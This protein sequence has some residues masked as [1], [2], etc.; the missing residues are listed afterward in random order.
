MLFRA[1]FGVAH[2]FLRIALG[3]VGV[4]AAYRYELPLGLLGLL[5][6]ASGIAGW[7]SVCDT[8]ESATRRWYQP[9]RRGPC[10]KPGSGAA[11]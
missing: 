1:R 10:R 3:T 5:L 7:C 9:R 4:V 11:A 6:I 8:A 2:R